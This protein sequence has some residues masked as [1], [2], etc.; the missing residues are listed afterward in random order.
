LYN[1]FFPPSISSRPVFLPLERSEFRFEDY[2]SYNTQAQAIIDAR[3]VDGGRGPAAVWRDIETHVRGEWPGTGHA[4]WCGHIADVGV[5]A[6][7]A[8]DEDRGCP[9][10]RFAA[11]RKR[12]I[13]PRAIV[14]LLALPLQQ[15]PQGKLGHLEILDQTMQAEIDAYATAHMDKR[16]AE[17]E[18]KEATA[19]PG[20]RKWKQKTIELG[21]DDLTPVF[22]FIVSHAALGSLN[23]EVAY[24]SD[25]FSSGL[26]RD[27]TRIMGNIEYL[28]TLDWRCRDA[29]GY[30]V[31]PAYLAEKVGQRATACD[32]YPLLLLSEL[33][34]FLA[35][36]VQFVVGD[37]GFG[38]PDR[39][40]GVF[41]GRHAAD[42]AACLEVASLAVAA[43]GSDGVDIERDG[44]SGKAAGGGKAGG[45]QGG[46]ADDDGGGS[47]DA[48]EADGQAEDVVAAAAAAPPANVMP[49]V[50]FKIRMRDQA[51]STIAQHLR[52][53]AQQ[54]EEDNL[55][56]S[57]QNMR[58][59]A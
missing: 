16:R 51:Y 7:A 18:A 4:E 10:H 54:R 41:L 44:S 34:V 28:E 20:A 47:A 31:A 55:R 33:F 22:C 13:F 57:Q 56:K 29:S 21:A 49:Q 6:G 32:E 25:F 12:I 45:D 30:I 35:L 24:V 37:D 8:G 23:A 15:T 3:V 26:S 43:A 46:A 42:T 58:R 39:F 53:I 1:F 19:E 59:Y 48:G 11:L 27:I 38:V 2:L 52:Q 9:C 14:A 36:Q 50:Q 40:A 5:L 17:E